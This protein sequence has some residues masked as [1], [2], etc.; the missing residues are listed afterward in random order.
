MPRNYG[1][2]KNSAEIYAK[3]HENRATHIEERRR[4]REYQSR[5]AD[6]DHYRPERILAWL[7]LGAAA[8]LI[9]TLA[10]N[11]WEMLK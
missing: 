2:P 5:L 8:C 1:H 7:C 6:A 4:A 11:T 9:M 10:L 3:L